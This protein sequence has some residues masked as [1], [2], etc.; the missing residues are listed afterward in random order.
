L[1][2]VCSVLPLMSSHGEDCVPWT[3]ERILLLCDFSA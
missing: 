3:W 2:I 1:I